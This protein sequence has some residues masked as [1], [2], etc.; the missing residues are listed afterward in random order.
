MK[1]LQITPEIYQELNN[2]LSSEDTGNYVMALMW[3]NQ[4]KLDDN[5][6]YI[7]LLY[8]KY[9]PLIGESTWKDNAGGLISRMEKKDIPLDVNQLDYTSM[10][11]I[12]RKQGCP[13]ELI[14]NLIFPLWA[15]DI[16]NHL[17]AWGDDEMKQ[18]TLTITYKE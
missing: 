9:C 17:I 1:K 11:A 13:K 2:Q 15:E 5:L 6:P 12:C 3:L 7:L 14:S 10:A 18:V 8:R 4:C 16:Q